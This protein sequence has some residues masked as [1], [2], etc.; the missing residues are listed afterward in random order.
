MSASVWRAQPAILKA[1][2]EVNNDPT[3]LP[4]HTVDWVWHDSACE[5][6]VGVEA[7]TTLLDA[8]EVDAV[9]GPGCSTVAI[10]SAMMLPYYDA[11]MVG[12]GTASPALSDKVRA[13]R[14][15][16]PSVARQSRTQN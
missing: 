6:T 12:I 13:A 14:K 7:I 1:V 3:L 15:L 2:R 10:N 11:P 4:D 5:G 9:F 16:R 8:F